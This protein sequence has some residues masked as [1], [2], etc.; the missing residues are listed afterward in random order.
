MGV[1]YTANY[2]IGV[3]LVNLDFEELELDIET[4]D[5]Y[6]DDLPSNEISTY[7]FEVGSGS[8]TGEDNEYYL[9]FKYSFKDGLDV[10][11]SKLKLFKDYL[12]SNKI[13]Y[14]GEIDLVGGLNVW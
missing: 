13:E 12:D 11:E 7:Y 8:Y 3:Q 5:E 10:L 14:I 1:D 2:G 9:C 6:L 4:M